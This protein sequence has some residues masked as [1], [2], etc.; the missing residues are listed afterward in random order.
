MSATPP[1]PVSRLF[2]AK[3]IGV[4]LLMAAAVGS[5]CAFFLWSLEVMTRIRF[6]HPWL[7]YGLPLAGMAVAWMYHR[8]GA[9]SEGGNNLILDRIHDPGG[10]VPRRMAP[11]VLFG[12]LV[13]HLF[14]GSAGREGT[15]VQIGGSLASAA[16]RRFN[17]DA[18]Q[19]RMLLM[20]GVAAGFGAVFGTPLAGAVFAVE[21]V[22]IG[23]PKLHALPLCL[24]ASFAGDWVCRAWGV[25]HT[26]YHIDG[27]AG[28]LGAFYLSP[29]LLGK[30]ALA[31]VVFG[32]VSLLF[33]ETCHRLAAGFKRWI[34]WPVLRP[35]AGGLMVIA[36]FF[37]VGRA[38]FL[39]LGVWSP[40]LD[41]VSLVSMFSGLQAGPWDWAWKLVFTAVTVSS[42]FKGGEVTP[43]FFIGAAL[44]SALAGWLGT[45]PELFAA[46]GFV[47][48]FAGATNTP[49]ACVLMGVEL[50]GAGHLVPMAIACGVAFLCSG[51]SGI[52]LSQRVGIPKPG[53]KG[54]GPLRGMRGGRPGSPGRPG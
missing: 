3:V 35:A 54:T 17:L 1:S 7:L 22:V 26:H 14:G 37:I 20:A 11:L 36:L 29:M 42:G 34:P 31:A 44:G 49:V 13:T 30:V 38:D 4:T 41:A 43:L 27:I 47:A 39:G 48:V 51:H 10:G 46:L 18:D 40:D 28:P 6:G 15:A 9:D 5:A 12:T 2:P 53:R 33:S 8:H 45:P 21:V 16:A 24:A 25:G 19:I 50:F 52:Y 32:L 23:R